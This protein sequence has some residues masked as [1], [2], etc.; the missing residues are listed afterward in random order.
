LIVTLQSKV[1]ASAGDSLLERADLSSLG[2]RLAQLFGRSAQLAASST[3]DVTL[4]LPPL[5]PR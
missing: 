5:G 2:D 1:D 3:T 4:D